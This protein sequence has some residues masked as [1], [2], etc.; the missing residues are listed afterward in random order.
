MAESNFYKINSEKAV[1]AEQLGEFARAAQIWINCSFAAQS[2]I[3][4]QWATHRSEFCLKQLG[5]GAVK[6][7][8]AEVKIYV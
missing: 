6:P 3:N 8:D 2:A 1:A 4:R 5:V 7:M